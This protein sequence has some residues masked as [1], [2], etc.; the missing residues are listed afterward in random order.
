MP[1]VKANLII[2]L[3]IGA[4]ISS[5]LLAMEP[6]T[7]YA[8]L[9]LE[10]PGVTAAYLFWGAVGGSAFAGIA[11]FWVVN[12][13]TYGLGAFAILSVLKLLTQPKA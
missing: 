6:L 9:S 2:A 7:D 3:A 13:L 8:F 5:V 4:L 12:A 1:S 10:W 11:I